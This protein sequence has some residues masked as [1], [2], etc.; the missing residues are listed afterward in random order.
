MDTAAVGLQFVSY[1]WDQA[2][3]LKVTFEVWPLCGDGLAITLTL[4][5]YNASRT[6]FHK[7]FKPSAGP[8]HREVIEETISIMP[9][10]VFLFYVEPNLDHD[11]DGVYLQD[12]EIWQNRIASKPALY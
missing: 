9:G 2:A 6:L 1:M 12:I 4:N 5:D 3:L 8:A 10:T 11:C 7:S